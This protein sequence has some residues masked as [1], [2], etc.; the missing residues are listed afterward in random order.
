MKTAVLI[1]AIGAATLG[2]QPAAMKFDFADATTAAGYTRVTPATFYT[3]ERGYGFE[4]TA[5]T[6]GQPPY[7]FSVHVPEEGNYKVTITLGDDRS[8][9]DTTVK[10]ELRRLMLEKIRTG[11]RQV[12]NPYLHRQ[13]PNVE[14]RNRRRSQ[15]EGSREDQRGLGLGR[16][17]DPRIHRPSSGCPNRRD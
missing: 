6:A 9:S 16:Q 3:P 11:P 5:Q 15:T 8:E 10:A 1:A 7:F 13:H 17:A 4:E 2:A 14:N 12:R